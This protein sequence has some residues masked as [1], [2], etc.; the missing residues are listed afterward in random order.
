MMPHECGPEA[1]PG[2]T[3]AYVMSR[4]PKLT[5]TFVLE[6]MRAVERAGV[7]VLLHPLLRERAGIQHPAAAAWT[8]RAR[9]VPFVSWAVVGSNLWFLRHRPGRFLRAVAGALAGTW[10]SLNFTIGA[11]GIL[12]KVVHAAR[13]M[14]EDGVDHVHCHFA[15]HPAV[16][17]FVVHR[18]TGI[19]FSFTAHGSDLHKDRHMLPQKVDEAAFVVTISADNRA[20]IAAECGPVAE[21]K[22]HVIRCGVDTAA[23]TSGEDGASTGRL[24]VV[25]I[26][27][28]E[29]VK[30]QRHLLDA[31]ALAV[32]SG[33][34]LDCDLVGD[35]PDRR[36]LQTHAAT[37]GLGDRVHFRGPLP[38][39]EVLR[40]LRRADVLVLPSVPTR[41]GKREGIPVVLMEAMSCER[42]V[43][44]SRLSGIPELV[45]DGV[46]GFLVEPGDVEGIATALKRLAAD[47]SLRER[48]GAAG[49][50]RVLRDHDVDANAARLVA[51]FASG[52]T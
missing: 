45:D 17:G 30:G 23:F 14:E 28:M 37:A 5:E 20:L 1:P 25:C 8:A 31:C 4:F 21:G 43:V 51:L 38:M 40:A 44:A 46:N 15:N 3:V 18:L 36:A 33:L 16:A 9:Y 29:E 34:D 12:P 47:P 27:R 2:R 39:P 32:A 22:V 52:V 13:L 42:P 26:G 35:G 48:M 50:A 24:R 11:L 7:R 6:E 10:G 19:P 49:R 41:S